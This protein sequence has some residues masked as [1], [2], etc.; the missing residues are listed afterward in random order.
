MICTDPQ[1]VK[2]EA[3]I[4]G[5]HLSYPRFLS[6]WSI[7]RMGPSVHWDPFLPSSNKKP[8]TGF[9]D[10]HMG[11]HGISQLSFCFAE[12]SKNQATVWIWIAV[13][14]AVAGIL[15]QMWG[16]TLENCQVQWIIEG[17]NTTGFP[18][19]CVSNHLSNYN[20]G[21]HPSGKTWE[22]SMQHIQGLKWLEAEEVLCSAFFFFIFFSARIVSDIQG[23]KPFHFPVADWSSISGLSVLP[24][25][26]TEWADLERTAW[27]WSQD[28]QVLGA[29]KAKAKGDVVLI[30]NEATL[31]G[32]PTPQ[33]NFFTT[34]GA[35]NHA[36]SLLG[37]LTGR[38]KTDRSPWLSAVKAASKQ[39]VPVA[40]CCM[41]HQRFSRFYE[42]T[43]IWPGV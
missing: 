17:C 15:H 11:Q 32:Q 23:S 30:E 24:N 28:A 34:W 14:L 43:P 39:V 38:P 9:I 18:H 6:F 33:P 41:W 27:A 12:G 35:G 1:A 16:P 5:I 29:Q 2:W 25:G 4:V 20:Y 40:T 3:I 31:L 19:C 37:T 13:L 26:A 22:Y 10:F 7:S 8:I 42:Q 21:V 36:G